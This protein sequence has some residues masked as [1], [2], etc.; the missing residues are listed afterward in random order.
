MIEFNTELQD[1]EKEIVHDCPLV[2]LEPNPNLKQWYSEEKFQDLIADPNFS[3]LRYGFEC[4]SG[5]AVLIKEFSHIAQGLVHYL[6]NNNVQPD[7]YIYAC[8]AKEKMGEF[9][10]QG[11]NNLIEPFKTLF[12]AYTIEIEKKSTKICENTGQD[13]C[14]CVRGNWYKTLSYEQSRLLGY[15]A[16]DVNTEKYWKERDIKNNIIV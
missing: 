8:I 12:R 11:D 13:G 1:W 16:V 10:W 4:N 5:W 3:N 9:T 7:A 2:Y 14:L 6:R 15:R